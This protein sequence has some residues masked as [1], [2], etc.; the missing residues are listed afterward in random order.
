MDETQMKIV[1]TIE[2]RMNSTRFPGKTMKEILGKPMLQLLIERVKNSNLIDEIIVATSKS[3]TDDVIEKLAI[4]MNVNCFRGS[5]EDV[6]SRVLFAAKSSNAELI[7]ELW[8]D[9]PLIDSAILDDLIRFYLK[10]NYDCVGTVLPNSDKNYPIGISALIFSTRILDEVDKITQAPD[11]REN[12]SNYIYEH[13]EKYKIGPFPCPDEL[14]Y[15][16]YRLTV[17]EQS[18]FEVIKIIFEKLYPSNPKFTAVDA[19]KFLN[20]NPQ[21]LEINKNIIQKRSAKEGF[22]KK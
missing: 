4:K 2:A 22:E 1:A 16:N 21:I 17:D 15:P 8:G 9:N 6:L 3:M 19:I 7:V 18:D 13:P 20:S 14:N 5:E 11:D 10:N 12:V